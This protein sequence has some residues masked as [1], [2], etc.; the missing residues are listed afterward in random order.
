MLET[1]FTQFSA[2]NNDSTV[3]S[4]G[5]ELLDGSVIRVG[6]VLLK[7]STATAK[8]IEEHEKRSGLTQLSTP[9]QSFTSSA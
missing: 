1:I 7:F 4:I 8:E 6:D 2:F 9:S 5:F 3:E